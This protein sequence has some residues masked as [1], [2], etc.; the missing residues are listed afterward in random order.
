LRTI[1]RNGRGEGGKLVARATRRYP[2]PDAALFYYRPVPAL[3][4]LPND[5]AVCI[6]WHS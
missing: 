1:A 6:A 5:A 4:W 3:H 2:R